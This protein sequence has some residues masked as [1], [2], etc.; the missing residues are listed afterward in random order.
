MIKTGGADIILL[1]V[2]LP[3]G[4]G[5]SLLDPISRENPSP[6]V[7]LITAFGEIDTAVEAMKQVRLI[8]FKNLSIFS[9]CSRPLTGRAKL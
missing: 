5:L 4:S 7:I 3:D 8:F 6:P 1:D 9:A 2:M